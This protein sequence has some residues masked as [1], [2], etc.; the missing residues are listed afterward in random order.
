MVRLAVIVNIPDCLNF[1][2]Y[3]CKHQRFSH[4]HDQILLN[5]LRPQGLPSEPDR[6]TFHRTERE[7]EIRRKEVHT[8]PDQLRALMQHALP[9]ACKM[10]KP[11]CDSSEE[12]TGPPA[13]SGGQITVALERVSGN[14]DVLLRLSTSSTEEV[15]PASRHCNTSP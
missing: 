15:P 3:Q 7:F 1:F 14:D 13:K 10:T 2:D 8:H 12:G 9:S 11:L 6:F 5:S 4:S